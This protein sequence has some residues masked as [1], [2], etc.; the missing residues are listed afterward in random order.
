MERMGP[1]G[2]MSSSTTLGSTHGTHNINNSNSNSSSSSTTAVQATNDDA[3]ASKLSCVTK[4]YISDDF[5][6]LFV[7]RSVKRAPIIN[8]GYYARWATMRKLLLQFLESDFPQ[9]KQ[10]LSLGAGFDTT[11]F[12]L[13]GEGR[14]PY[15]YVEVDFVE[16]TKKKTSLV[17]SKEVLLSK[18][19]SEQVEIDPG[20]GEIVSEHYSLLPCDLRNLKDMDA[21]FAKAGLDAKLPTL[22]FAE[23]VLIYL[24]PAVSRHVVKWCADK[25]DSAA[26]IIYEQILPD[27]AFGQQML[28]NLESRGCPLLGLHDTPTLESKE[29][30]FTDLGWQRA[31]A[32]DMD[33]IYHQQLDPVDRSRIERLEIFDEFEEWNIMQAHYCV[34]YGI[35]D[36]IGIFDNFG[37]SDEKGFVSEEPTLHMM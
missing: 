21:A 12:Q 16:V 29:R 14:A 24:D 37:F 3:T 9:K 19:G 31:L 13:V 28:R 22:I 11:F 35:K 34:S 25:F 27:D 18:L 8:R 20:K 32:M 1:P 7:R 30:R 5:V 6:H 26:L 23:C 4:G 33:A 10:I 2:S 17:A 15:K 36:N